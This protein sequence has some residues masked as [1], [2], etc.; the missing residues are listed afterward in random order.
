MMSEL[1]RDLLARP[2]PPPAR[3]A[4]PAAAAAAIRDTAPKSTAPPKPTSKRPAVADP[5][6]PAAKKAMFKKEKKL[7]TDGHQSTR[8]GSDKAMQYVRIL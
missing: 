8:E 4:L 7:A 6:K 5:P 2:P 1:E 3:P